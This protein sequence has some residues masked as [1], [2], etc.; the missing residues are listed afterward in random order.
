MPIYDYQCHMCRVTFTE[1]KNF[2]DNGVECPNCHAVGTD[3]YYNE[4]FGKD[5]PQV[6]RIWFRINVNTGFASSAGPVGGTDFSHVLGE[7][8]KYIAS[9]KQLNEYLKMTRDKYF[10]QTNGIQSVMRP[11]QNET[12]GE[13]TM[14][15]FSHKTEGVDLG[16]L[17]VIDENKGYNEVMSAFDSSV[18]GGRDNETLAQAEA[19]LKKAVGV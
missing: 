6:G 4:T 16:E 11:V 5:T 3:T 14:E 12:T 13:I 18:P 17:H 8:G 2:L 9:E 1:Q 15:K 19:R 7:D 10:D